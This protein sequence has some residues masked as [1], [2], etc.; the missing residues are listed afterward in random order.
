MLSL[1]VLDS[2]FPFSYQKEYL[3]ISTT[4]GKVKGYTDLSR[5]GRQYYAFLGIPYAAPPV[6][7]LRFEV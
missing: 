5:D 1:G 3:I 4:D 2:G 7:E 6:M